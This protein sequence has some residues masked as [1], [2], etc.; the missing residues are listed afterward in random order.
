MKGENFLSARNYEHITDLY[1]YAQ[2]NVVTKLKKSVSTDLQRSRNTFDHNLQ[3]KA[4]LST[5]YIS[6]R[7]AIKLEITEIE[8]FKMFSFLEMLKYCCK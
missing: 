4:T 8:N 6:G 5:H 3:T 2:K 1:E 7:N